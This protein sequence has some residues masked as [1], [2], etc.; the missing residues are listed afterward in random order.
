MIEVEIRGLLDYGEYRRVLKYLHT[1]SDSGR[2]DDKIAYYYSLDGGIL[3]L[4][5]EY[6]NKKAKLSLKIG[7]EFKGNGMK[8]YELYF[9]NSVS[10]S[11]CQRLLQKIGYKIKSVVKQKRMNFLYRGVGLSLKHT[12]DWG[13]HF[14]AEILVNN[15]QQVPG[16]KKKLY[17]VCKELSI[18]PMSSDEL[19]NFISR[20]DTK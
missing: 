11:D 14:E 3:K 1:H 9:K 7:N 6:S 4:V 10:M 12:R 20:L 18:H 13:Y 15:P 17:F 16:A 2:S 19:F 8:E 5:N